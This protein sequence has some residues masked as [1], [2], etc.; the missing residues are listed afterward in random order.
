LFVVIPKKFYGVRIELNLIDTNSERS[1]VDNGVYFQPA[2]IYFSA[3]MM[4]TALDII[5]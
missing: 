3:Y 4:N 5:C 2:L 1:K